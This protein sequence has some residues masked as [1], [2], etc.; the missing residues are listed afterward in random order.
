MKI[1]KIDY[2]TRKIEF[3]NCIKS[4]RQILVAPIHIT[5]ILNSIHFKYIDVE[6]DWL[7]LMFY[8]L[9]GRKRN[10]LSLRLLLNEKDER[11]QYIKI[12]YPIT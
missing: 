1:Y 12:K 2:S 9:Q 4:S 10:S 7:I 6:A 5:K 3:S 8:K 11:L